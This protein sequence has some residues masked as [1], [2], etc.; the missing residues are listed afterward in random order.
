MKILLVEDHPELCEWVAKSLRQSGYAV[1]IAA[2]GDHAE[3]FLLTGEYDGVLLDLSLPDKDGLEVLKNLRTRGLQVP[4]LIFTARGSVDDRI[5]GLNLGADDYLPKPFELG[6]LEA[7][8]KALL[9]RSAGQ[10]PVVRLGAL[11]F[12]T[13]SR[14]TTIN[15]TPLSLTPRELAV[16]EVLLR[17]IGRPVA[18]D[19]LFEKLFSMEQ[20]A[21]PEAIEIYVSRLRKKLE[22]SGVAVT[23]V[24]GIGY[25][26]SATDERSA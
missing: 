23:T 8:L 18:R 26:I 11:A 3:H 19:A 16:L 2:R 7:R 24:R 17:R 21:R 20:D 4:V 12:D 22:G 6:E 9:R 14:L 1:D 15:D 25:L 5:R 10:T 13:V